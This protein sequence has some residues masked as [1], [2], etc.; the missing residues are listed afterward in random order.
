MDSIESK[1]CWCNADYL[2]SGIDVCTWIINKIDESNTFLAGFKN[3]F[4]WQYNVLFALLIII[5][6]FFYT[7]ITIPVNQMAD[8]LKRNGGLYRK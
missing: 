2:C 7:A 4:S 6:S 5:F 1:C 8:D 3:V